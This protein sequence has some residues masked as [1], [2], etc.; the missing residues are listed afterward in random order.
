MD[1]FCNDP[2]VRQAAIDKGVDKWRR[3]ARKDDIDAQKYFS[4]T[5]DQLELN[6]KVESDRLYTEGEPITEESPEEMAIKSQLES[7][8][9]NRDDG[10]DQI[11]VCTDSE[12]SKRNGTT[13]VFKEHLLDAL[14]SSLVKNKL[15]QFNQYTFLDMCSKSIVESGRCKIFDALESCLMPK[16]MMKCAKEPLTMISIDMFAVHISTNF[17][18]KNAPIQKISKREDQTIYMIH[19]VSNNIFIVNVYHCSRTDECPKDH[20]QWQGYYFLCDEEE[21]GFDT[22]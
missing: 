21:C 10:V 16:S 17:I 12:N 20:F 3:D 13:G 4:M 19:Y 7:K 8:F 15:S 1:D 18:G 11:V 22:A 5:R 9:I 14:D 2:R 6:I